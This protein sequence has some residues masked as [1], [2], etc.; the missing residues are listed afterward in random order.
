MEKY[1]KTEVL[2]GPQ[3]GGH[4]I[5]MTSL[6]FLNNIINPA[7]EAAGESAV[8]N[9]KFLARIEDE[10]DNLGVAENFSVTTS[11]GAKREVK[12]YQLNFDQMMLVGM[13]ESKAVRRAVLAKLKALDEQ[14]R[15]PQVD[16]MAALNDP[17]AMRGLLLT[18]TEK[19][20]VLQDQV[21]EMLPDV[22]ALERIAKSDGGMCPTD[23]A[24]HLQ[25]SPKQLFAFM[26]AND[27]AYKRTGGKN[28]V[29]YQD[30]IKAGLLE[31]K[32]TVIQKPDGEDRVCTQLLVT[33]KGM[34]KLTKLLAA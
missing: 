32:V 1:Q 8:E 13:R 22:D 29:A 5:T 6:D 30:K 11:Q 16:P 34:V 27:W 2:A 21:N 19:V 33:P 9:R 14:V 25:I 17:A 15:A 26:A 28:W 18:Y 12:G 31:H 20:L 3:S 23:A 10:I 7:R 24:K 4:A